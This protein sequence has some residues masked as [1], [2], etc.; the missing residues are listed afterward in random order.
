[1]QDFWRDIK[2]ILWSPIKMANRHESTSDNWLGPIMI[3]LLT[4]AL[5]IVMFLAMQARINDPVSS[6]LFNLNVPEEILSAFDNF[7]A[8]NSFLSLT[9]GVSVIP[10][11]IVGA[12]VMTC[13]AILLN[14]RENF[15]KVAILYGYAHMPLL[16]YAFIVIMLM[17][18]WPPT[19]E[20]NSAASSDLASIASALEA[21]RDEI[22]Q[23]PTM[24]LVV[25]LSYA[26]QLW[27]LALLAICASVVQ[28]MT[29]VKSTLA[30]SFY[31]AVI[32]MVSLYFAR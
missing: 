28:R 14:G 23:T 7:K 29:Y 25:V 32:L 5:H 24:K 10:F 12:G 1:M 27:S 19:A 4:A 8:I 13:W 21:Y 30:A 17:S 20:I 2:D 6:Y 26:A 22:L 15:R 16:I 11:W 9:G 18:F 3:V 31:G